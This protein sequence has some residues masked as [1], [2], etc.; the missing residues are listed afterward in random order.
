MLSLV[1]D[2]IY[3]CVKNKVNIMDIN[4]MSESERETRNSFAMAN[5]LLL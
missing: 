5:F 2:S 3:L 4:N 1:I